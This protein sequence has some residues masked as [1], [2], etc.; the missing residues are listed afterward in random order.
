M[1]E[2]DD[3]PT[4]LACSTC[5][6]PLEWVYRYRD[7]KQYAIVRIDGIDDPTVV[8][9]H[10]CRLPGVERT[11]ANLPYQPPE[12]RRRGAHRARLVVRQALKRLDEKKG[13]DR[14]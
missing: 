12:V 7:G 4:T 6:Q 14:G 1:I 11:W 5:M 13:E 3:P 2:I 8:K 10:S 9:L